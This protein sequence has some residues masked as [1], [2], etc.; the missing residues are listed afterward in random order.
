MLI[1]EDNQ[2]FEVG[3][4]VCFTDEETGLERPDNLPKAT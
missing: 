4:T 3:D 2:A 1:T